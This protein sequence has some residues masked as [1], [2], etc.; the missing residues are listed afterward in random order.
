MTDLLSLIAADA[1]KHAILLDASTNGPDRLIGTA[2]PEFI[3]GLGGRD[4]IDG[5]RGNDTL[6]GGNGAD[7]ILGGR[8]D[9]ILIG[10][11]GDDRLFG[12]RGGD[13]I[14][15]G[16]GRDVMTGN[17][18][19]DVFRF[20]APLA[21]LGVIPD[22]DVIT[23]FQLG[24]DVIDLL[25]YRGSPNLND[26]VTL[27]GLEDGVQVTVDQTGQTI[28]LRGLG[29]QDVEDRLPEIIRFSAI[30]D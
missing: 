10:Q 8:G 22:N 1:R 5:R 3:S 15:G 24:R 12:G 27:A 25:G 17:Q 26:V 11:A 18:G 13:S 19:N 2:G 30:L 28:L 7:R 6:D 4:F 9:D 23:D 16:A 21:D 14:I 29:L 20:V